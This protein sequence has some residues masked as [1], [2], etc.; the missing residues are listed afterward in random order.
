MY[1]KWLKIGLRFDS[2]TIIGWSY[3]QFLKRIGWKFAS[4][5]IA[6]TKIISTINT[7][8]METNNLETNRI[9]NL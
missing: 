4:K 6:G 8:D 5:K 2:L 7:Y 9:V 3:E 1:T